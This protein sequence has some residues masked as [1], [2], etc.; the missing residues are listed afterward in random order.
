MRFLYGFN[1][2]LGFIGVDRVLGSRS[3]YRGVSKVL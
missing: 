2:V 3:V 1:M